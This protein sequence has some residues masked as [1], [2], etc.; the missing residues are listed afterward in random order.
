ML[1]VLHRIGTKKKEK[2]FDKAMAAVSK[3][4]SL[5]EEESAAIIRYAAGIY[6]LRRNEKDCV[7]DDKRDGSVL[8]LQAKFYPWQN[9]AFFV[10]DSVNLRSF[11]EDS[12]LRNWRN[13]VFIGIDWDF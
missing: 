13:Q 1:F 10:R 2:L 5:K 6:H 11:V 8:S 12:P 9:I 4:G 7:K 3:D